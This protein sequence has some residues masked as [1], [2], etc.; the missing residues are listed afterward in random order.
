MVELDPSLPE[1]VQP[2][3]SEKGEILKMVCG[4]KGYAGYARY[5]GY[6]HTFFSLLEVLLN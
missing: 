3:R 5:A 4:Y 6:A 1:L 2:V